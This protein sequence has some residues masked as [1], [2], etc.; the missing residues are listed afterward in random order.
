[1]TNNEEYSFTVDGEHHLERV[2]RFVSDVSEMTRSRV[3]RLISSEHLRVNGALVKPNHKVHENDEI[4]IAIPPPLR[5][6]L[7]PEDLPVDIIYQD[8]D[9]IVLHKAPGMVVHPGPGNWTGT[10]VHALLFHVPDL[11]R[12]GEA[13]RPGIVHRLDRDTGGL[14]VVAKHEKSHAALVDQFASRQ[15]K[16][17]YR[18]VTVGSMPEK[19]G[20]ID[21]PI[22]RHRQYRHKMTVAAHGRDARTEYTIKNLYAGMDR[23]FSDLDITLHTGRTHQI[24]VHLS[25]MAHPIVGDPVYSKKPGVYRVPYLLLYAVALGFTH[26]GS[27]EWMEFSVEVPDYYRD[28]LGRMTPIG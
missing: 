15:V 23:K 2:D 5:T 11:G 18:A 6:T 25:S 17:K 3:Q 21:A 19:K 22:G 14:M 8:E 12:S 28:F 13:E 10:L 16:K 27:G 4:T 20:M 26:P 1:M 7:E 24:R 9:V